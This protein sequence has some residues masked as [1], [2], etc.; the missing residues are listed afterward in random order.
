MTRSFI[1]PLVLFSFYRFEYESADI[2]L[3]GSTQ[4]NDTIHTRR[5][6]HGIIQKGDLQLR[7][8]W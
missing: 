5:Y 2:I 4:L 7:S 3:A 1:I 6:S 8:L